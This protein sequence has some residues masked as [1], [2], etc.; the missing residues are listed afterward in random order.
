MVTIDNRQQLIEAAI[1][2]FNADYSAPLEQVAERAG[3]T[4]RTL[5]RYFKGREELLASCVQDM[6]RS[7]YQAL[8][9][10]LDSSPEP[11]VQLENML[12]ACVDCGAKYAFLTSL[13]T[14]PT[15]PA[16]A[17]EQSDYA[18]L[19]ARCHAVILAVQAQGLISAHLPAEWVALLMSGIVKATIDAQ[20]SGTATIT[21]LKQLAWFSFSKGIGL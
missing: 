12:Y 13:V 10:A 9:G 2:V 14:Q 7:C 21:Q 8:S 1:L 20:A 11:L 6:Q 17:A 19:Q 16:L 18:A 15:L 3:L 4:R 5:H